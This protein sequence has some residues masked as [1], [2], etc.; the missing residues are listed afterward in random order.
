MRLILTILAL[1]LAP[2]GLGN[3]ADADDGGL[4]ARPTCPG[5]KCPPKRPRPSR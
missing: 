2:L 3:D 5:G 1:W 4:R